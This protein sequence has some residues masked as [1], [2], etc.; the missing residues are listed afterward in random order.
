MK[1]PTPHKLLRND[2]RTVTSSSRLRSSFQIP[3]IWVWS[4]FLGQV[5]S[6]EARSWITLGSRWSRRGHDTS[7]VCLWCRTSLSP[8][9]CEAGPPWSEL[10]QQSPGLF[11]TFLRPFLSSSAGAAGRIKALIALL[12]L[13]LHF[14]SW[15]SILPIPVCSTCSQKKIV[16]HFIAPSVHVNFQQNMN[17]QLML[18]YSA[19]IRFYT[20]T[21]NAQTCACNPVDPVDRLCCTGTTIWTLHS[22][23][24]WV[25]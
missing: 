14:R 2:P 18:C 12:W 19:H 6:T 4:S 21:G 9:W 3:Q 20:V 25:D 16:W 15:E 24:I 13:S 1:Q 17:T 10:F 5:W 22:A 23:H 7:R 8:V 11:P